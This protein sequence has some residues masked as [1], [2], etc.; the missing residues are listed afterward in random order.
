VEVVAEI[1]VLWTF[2]YLLILYDL[3]CFFVEYGSDY[4]K[5]ITS[6]CQACREMFDLVDGCAQ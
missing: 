4:F 3:P 1:P 6:A 2:S 5:G